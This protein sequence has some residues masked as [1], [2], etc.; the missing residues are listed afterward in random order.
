MAK[1]RQSF[2]DWIKQVGR[3]NVA[4]QLGV[5]Y[6]VAMY[7][8]KGRATPRPDRIARI[9]ELSEGTLT[10]DAVIAWP[11]QLAAMEAAKCNS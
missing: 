1:K 8:E 4:R 2:G 3:A 5:T 10:A 9:V 6:K 11:G 7:W